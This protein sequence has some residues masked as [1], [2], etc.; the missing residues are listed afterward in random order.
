M[1]SIFN[2]AALPETIGSTWLIAESAEHLATV[3]DA[4]R[5]F[6]T[7]GFAL[8]PEDWPLR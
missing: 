3:A 7:E 5:L 8:A 4:E 2:N 1:E 6:A